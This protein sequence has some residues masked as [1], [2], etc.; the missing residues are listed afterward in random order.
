MYVFLR[1][2]NGEHIYPMIKLH[3]SV[4][5][6]CSNLSIPHWILWLQW[7]RLLV[8]C[9]WIHALEWPKVMVYLVP[10]LLNNDSALLHRKSLPRQTPAVDVSP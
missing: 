4:I 10:G 7:M 6:L 2:K 3:V 8:L 5:R 1:R 9:M